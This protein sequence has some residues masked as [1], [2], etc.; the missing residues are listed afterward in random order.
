MP[1]PAAKDKASVECVPAPVPELD[2]VQLVI[3]LSYVPLVISS[4]GSFIDEQKGGYK[5]YFKKLINPETSKQ[6]K[7]LIFSSYSQDTQNFIDIS[8]NNDIEFTSKTPYGG[9]HFALVMDKIEDN[10][11]KRSL[12]IN[13]FK[14]I[15][16]ASNN[17]QVNTRGRL[18]IGRHKTYTPVFTNREAI[19]LPYNSN[20]NSS[21]FVLSF[22]CKISEQQTSSV[23]NIILSSIDMFDFNHLSPS[24]EKQL[25]KLIF[26]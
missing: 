14:H 19:D 23:G 21:D 16:D 11:Y 2:V 10:R 1:E 15:E 4:V 26:F 25:I 3:L 13:S 22:W 18:N 5:L 17:Y 6:D 20:Y 12:Y 7:K 9:I 8:S 24:L